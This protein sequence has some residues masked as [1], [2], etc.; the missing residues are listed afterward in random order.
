MLDF[1][2]GGLEVEVVGKRV[3]FAAV[4]GE[5]DEQF[6]FAPP[7]FSDTKRGFLVRWRE[8][9]WV[10]GEGGLVKG[11]I[12]CFAFSPNDSWSW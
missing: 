5:V 12:L 8:L 11:G 3:G 2:F 4:V 7:I 1:V 6:E 9:E 10:R